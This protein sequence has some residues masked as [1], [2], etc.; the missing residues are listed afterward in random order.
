M[1]SRCKL[2]FRGE[3]GTDPSGPSEAAFVPAGLWHLDCAPSSPPLCCVCSVTLGRGAGARTEGR[4]GS[5]PLCLLADD[6]WTDF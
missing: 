4:D 1:G 5:D 2:R 3:A 6:T